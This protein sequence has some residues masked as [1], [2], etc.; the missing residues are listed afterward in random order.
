MRKETL[1]RILVLSLVSGVALAVLA[2][3]QTRR[4]AAIEIHAT[5]PQR[6]GWLTSN[7]S[8]RVGEPLHLR[9]ISDDVVHGFAIGQLDFQPIDLLPGQPVEVTLIFDQP[10]TYIFY[11]TR[12]CGADHWR[13]RGTIIVSGNAPVTNEPPEP[14]LYLTLGLDLDASHQSGSIPAQKP[15]AQRGASLASSMPDRLLAGDYRTQSPFALWA[16]LRAYP[17]AADLNDQQ[18]W[19]LVAWVWQQQTTPQALAEGEALYQRDCA[20][21]HGV[22]GDG[23]G[24]YSQNAAFPDGEMTGASESTFGHGTQPAAAFTDPAR[25]LGASPALLQ[26]KI[27]RGGMGTGMPSWGLIYTP[28]QTWALVDYLWTFLFEYTEE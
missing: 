17:E 8:A 15:S 9:L 10:G 27:L 21:C 20:T 1:A 26:G 24:V 13:M 3:W 14:P 5:M 28:E 16:A 18:L 25:M 22:N 11:C 6:G 23:D 2:A 4:T 19:D 7:L 12:W